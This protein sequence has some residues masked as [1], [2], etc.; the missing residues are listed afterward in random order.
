MASTADPPRP[1]F[2]SEEDEDVLDMRVGAS[3]VTDDEDLRCCATLALRPVVEGEAAGT[4]L[5]FRPFALFPPDPPLAPPPPV[6][7]DNRLRLPPDCFGLTDEGCFACED[8]DED[9]DDDDGRGVN[10]S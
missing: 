4:L 8:D 3:T 7:L 9:D 1:R 10:C 5:D 6:V 2:D